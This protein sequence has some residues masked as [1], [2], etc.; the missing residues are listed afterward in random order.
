LRILFVTATRL[1]DAVLT[2]GLLRHLL[3]A[4]PLARF[5]V[6]CGPIAAGVFARM[7]RLERLIPVTKQR[8]D[9]HWWHLWKACVGTHWDLAI[10]LRG[11][12]FI[13]LLRAR[14]RAVMSGGRRPGHRL[15][16]LAEALNLPVPPLP[17]AWIAPED[18]NVAAAL[19]P[20]DVPLIGLCPTSAIANKIWPAARFAALFHELSRTLPGARAVIFGGLGEQEA[21]AVAPVLA[22]VPGAIN[23]VGRVSLPEA[24]A[25]LSRCVLVV[26]N[27]SGLTHLSASTGAPTLGLFGPTNFDE[28]APAGPFTAVALAD[29]PIGRAPMTDLSVGTALEAAEALLARA[30]VLRPK[31]H[32]RE[33]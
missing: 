28:Y 3:D 15:V 24:A 20:A 13:F 31:A 12:A 32:A 5:T 17:I 11:S 25:C 19:L 9:L 8:F 16:H 27:D 7:P 26:G 2:T 4:Y 29:G 22:A 30:A 10:D 23:L 6:C 33:G 14:K 21:A 1:G 18:Y